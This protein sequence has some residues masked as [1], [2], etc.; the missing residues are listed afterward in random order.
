MAAPIDALSDKEKQTLR[1]L[2]RGYDAKS[3]ARHLGLSVHTVNERLR[4]ARRKL[5]VS[6][7]REAARLLHQ[8]EGAEPQSFGD[9]GLG[10]ASARAAAQA[11]GQ[12]AQGDGI[13]RRTG[14]II[15]GLAMTISLALLALSALSGGVSAPAAAPLATSSAQSPAVDAAKQWLALVDGE[16]WNAAW[17][18]TGQSFRRNNTVDGWTAAA[19]GV[20]AKYGATSGRSLISS[21]WVPAPPSGYRIIKFRTTTSKLGVITETLSLAEEGG[22]WRVVGIVID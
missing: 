5:S 13:L 14:W 10:D 16:N 17:T 20:R 7:S 1:L 19:T 12:P 15:G 11:D 18:E 2:L 22:A 6:S 8:A 4:D 21:E 9:D 3:S